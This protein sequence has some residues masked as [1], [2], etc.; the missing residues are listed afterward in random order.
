MELHRLK[1]QLKQE[2]KQ[3]ETR[4]KRFNLKRWIFA[5][6]GIVMLLVVCFPFYRK[7]QLTAP[8]RLFSEAVELESLRNTTAAEKKYREVY[9]NYPQSQEAAESLF[10]IGNIWRFDHQD[11]QKALLNYLKLEH[12]YPHNPL[13]LPAREEAARIVKYT[14]RDYSRAIE[15]YQRLLDFNA[16]NPA[17]YYYEIADCYFYLEN[18]SQARIELES[19]LEKYPQSDL[20]P[21]ALYRKARILI[22]E[23]LTEEARRDWLDI[24][25]RYPGSKH[26]TQAEFDL[27]KILEEEGSLQEALQHYQQLVGKLEPALLE[28][29]IKH[30]EQRIEEKREAI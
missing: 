27:A 18:Y 23:G 16:G 6:A 28:E 7:Q 11:M 9:Q 20:A 19:L 13:V 30:L 5:V 25:E 8:Q 17:Q 14:Q 1:K 22:L 10:R 15:F 29:K 12:D 4:K 2:L 26:R 21:D 3:Q 24:I